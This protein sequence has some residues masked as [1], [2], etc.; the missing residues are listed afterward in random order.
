MIS[1]AQGCCLSV[2]LLYSVCSAGGSLYSG[3]QVSGDVTFKFVISK[4]T[5]DFK[6]ADI[7]HNCARSKFLG[8]SLTLLTCVPLAATKRLTSAHS[9]CVS[10]CYWSIVLSLLKCL[11]C[12]VSYFDLICCDCLGMKTTYYLTCFHTKGRAVSVSVGE[13]KFTDVVTGI[14]NTASS[15]FTLSMSWLFVY[16]TV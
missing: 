7:T 13:K 12:F 6:A 9:H 14:P 2:F 5:E 16:N 3:G 8:L 1:N 11:V 15:T 10:Y 4:R